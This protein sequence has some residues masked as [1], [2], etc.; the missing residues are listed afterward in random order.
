[1]YGTPLGFFPFL[2]PKREIIRI[3]A[4]VIGIEQKYKYQ[5][6]MW[7]SMETEIK[8]RIKFSMPIFLYLI[9]PRNGNYYCSCLEFSALTLVLSFHRILKAISLTFLTPSFSFKFFIRSFFI[10]FSSFIQVDESTSMVKT[11]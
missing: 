10:N 6:V 1:M 9:Y 11:P 3:V 8:C 5:F 7:I 4:K 2:F